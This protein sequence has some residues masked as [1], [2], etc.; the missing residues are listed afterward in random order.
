MDK[1]IYF[2]HAVGAHPLSNEVVESVVRALGEAPQIPGRGVSFSSDSLSQCRSKLALLLGVSSSQIILTSGAT[3][4]LN[5]AI[6]GLNLGRGDLVITT[7]MEHN[8]VLRPLAHLEDRRGI[9]VE[10]VSVNEEVK[11]NKG[12]Y[13]RLL[14]EKPR[15]VVMT[16]SSNVTGRI[17]PVKGWFED[18]K[19]AG[20][21][22]LLDASQTIGRIPVVANDLHADMVAF[23]GYK[24]LRGP[25]GTGALYVTPQI[26]L[27]PIFTGGTGVWS[28]FPLQPEEMPM[29]LEPGTP[30]MPGFAGLDAAL[31]YY[32]EHSCDV[33]D[34]EALMTAGLVSGLRAIPSVKVFDEDPLERLPVISFAINGVDAETAGFIL[35][36]SFGIKCRAGLH[37]A[38]LM[39][40]ALGVDSTV[41]FSPSYSNNIEDID[42]ALD[43]VK[44]VAIM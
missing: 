25:M 37:C 16:H 8:S 28:D 3:Y 9:R 22:T 18:A 27:E 23:S 5:T 38:P 12:V 13:D 40:K 20:A 7:V 6:L 36:E 2:N 33:V 21:L 11:L 29:R 24:G 41:R 31:S 4:G 39:H 1:Y 19:S 32:M 10:Y 43:A 34:K 26:M 35:S 15:L 17:N 30:N 44:R 14:V 42:Y